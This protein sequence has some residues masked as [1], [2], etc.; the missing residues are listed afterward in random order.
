MNSAESPGPVVV[1]VDG[2]DAAIGAARWA[3]KEAVHRDVPLRLV[4]VIQ[5]PD[6]PMSSDRADAAEHDFAES[7]LRAARL[8]VEESGLPVKIDT[9]AVR[10]CRSCTDRRVERRQPHLRRICGDRSG[11]QHGARVDR[12][13]SCRGSALSRGD[14]SAR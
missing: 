11:G 10:R 6:G 12:G 8:A 7:S 5:I 2:S 4:C 13:D 9:A 1:G 14:Y 3:A